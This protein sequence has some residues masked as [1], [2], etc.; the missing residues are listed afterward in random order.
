MDVEI[1]NPRLRFQIAQTR[2]LGSFAQGGFERTFPRFEMPTHLQPFAEAAVVVKEEAAGGVD[3]EQARSHMSRRERPARE[4]RGGRPDEL[5]QL[6]AM[7]PLTVVGG[8][9]TEKVVEKRHAH[10]GNHWYRKK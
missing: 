2:L 5:D 7:L 4:R 10:A 1:E 3:D 9:V 6:P 8:C